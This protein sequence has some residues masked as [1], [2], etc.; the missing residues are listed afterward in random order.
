[1]AGSTRRAYVD[2]SYCQAARYPPGKIPFN[3]TSSCSPNRRP[4]R[5]KAFW[6][7]RFRLKRAAYAPTP[8][9]RGYADPARQPS[10]ECEARMI[11]RRFI[12]QARSSFANRKNR[13][14]FLNNDSYRV[15]RLFSN[16]WPSAFVAFFS[17]PF[18]VLYKKMRF[19]SHQTLEHHT[20]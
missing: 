19:L 5:A 3:R 17:K 15:A 16:E 6:C 12:Y 2:G 20:K 10:M 18:G 14:E 13:V 9:L 8:V 7:R 4:A 11:R 1:M